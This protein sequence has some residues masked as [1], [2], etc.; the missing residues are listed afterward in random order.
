VALLAPTGGAAA[1]VHDVFRSA[2]Q[3]WTASVDLCSWE[4]WACHLGDDRTTLGG[5][6]L[7]LRPAALQHGVTGRIETTQFYQGVVS[8]GREQAFQYGGRNDYYVS[9]NGQQAGLLPGSFLDL[10]GETRYGEDISQIVGSL[11]SPVLAMNLP[12]PGQTIT[13][14][15]GVKYTQALSEQ[16]ILFGGK[17]NLLDG[18]ILNYSGG[19][20]VDRFQNMAL[21]FNPVLAR[22]APYSTIGVGAAVLQDL[23]PV[24]SLL[25]LDAV[26]R[27]TE[28]GID[29][30]F[31]EGAVVLAEAHL[32]VTIAGRPGHQI[33]GGTWSSRQYAALS[34]TPLLIAPPELGLVPGK[35]SGSWSLYYHFDQTLGIDPQDP[36]RSWGMFGMFGLADD[37]TN[38]FQW[39]ISLGLSGHTLRSFRPQD[40]W[41]A[42]WYYLGGSSTLK[43]ATQRFLPLQNGQGMEVFYKVNVT[44][45]FAVTPNLQWIQ[46]GIS[47]IDDAVT[48]GLRGKLSF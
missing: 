12:Q 47:A 33:F 30:L 22:T 20:G 16:F 2:D 4:D 15:T 36:Q 37:Q 13:A 21:V 27:A 14:L 3:A 46:P 19:R 24:F 32:P 8:G 43:D 40:E 34:D 17:L 5:D 48:L 44:P 29:D 1:D 26:D 39:T 41:G 45:W 11:N 42:G 25:V 6:L 28:W 10:H 35:E 7:G 18:L 38:P 23:Q 9:V 31:S